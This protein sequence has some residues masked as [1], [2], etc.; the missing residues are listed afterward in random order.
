MTLLANAGDPAL[1][2]A[3]RRVTKRRV[4]YMAGMF[5]EASRT[6]AE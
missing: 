3:M 5:A 1:A 6:P 4:S 2:A